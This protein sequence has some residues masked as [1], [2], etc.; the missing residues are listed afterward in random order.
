MEFLSVTVLKRCIVKSMD[1]HLSIIVHCVNMPLDT[2]DV[3]LA[4]QFGAAKA[5]GSRFSVKEKIARKM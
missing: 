4:R 2:V 5:N 3:V 1:I